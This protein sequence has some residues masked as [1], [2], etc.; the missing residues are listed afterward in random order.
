M[1][2]TRQDEE[3][4]DD[5]ELI[6]IDIAL[7]DLNESKNFGPNFEFRHN[8]VE[9]ASSERPFSDRAHDID[10]AFEIIN[11]KLR[12]KVVEGTPEVYK[13]IMERCWN[14]NPSERPDLSFLINNMKI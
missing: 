14:A 5:K 9:L 6:N 2:T 3:V 12:P 10:L 4:V 11:E 8:Y 13:N 1:E 7:K